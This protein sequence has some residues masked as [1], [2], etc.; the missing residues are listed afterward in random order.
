VAEYT[1]KSLRVVVAEN[2]ALPH[3]LSP[4][5]LAH[6][7][8][9]PRAR[10]H[11]TMSRMRRAGTLRPSERQFA[12]TAYARVA[13]AVGNASSGFEAGDGAALDPKV[14]LENLEHEVVLSDLDRRRILSRIARTGP[15]PTRVL[16]C[17]EL[18]LIE[19]ST[20]RSVGPP[21][22]VSQEELI[23]RLTRI[24]YAGGEQIARAAFDAAEK[25]W[26]RDDERSPA[27]MPYTEAT[28]S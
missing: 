20:G 16:A 25:L 17:K 21:E 13:P 18:E 7:L 15:A 3:P 4:S 24:V 12:R 26:R 22:P 2:L 10:I 5:E 11:E 19:R 8:G 23:V 28:E 9:I 27:Y 1:R 6:R 14:L